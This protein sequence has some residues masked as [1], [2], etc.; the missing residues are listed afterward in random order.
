[1]QY[2]YLPTALNNQ[3]MKIAKQL[4]VD[5]LAYPNMKFM[6]EAGEEENSKAKP[7]YADPGQVLKEGSARVDGV[8]N[9]LEETRV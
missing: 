2:T 4:A 6:V 7:P 1:M 9:G 3:E 8:D 5:G